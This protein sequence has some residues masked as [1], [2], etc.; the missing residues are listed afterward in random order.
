MANKDNPNGFKPTYTLSGGPPAIVYIPVANAQTLA[1][2]DAITLASG[3]VAI[4]TT[5]SGTIDG[6]MAAPSVTA[7]TNTLVP[8]YVANSDT[9]FEGQCSGNSAIALIGTSVDIEGTTGIMEVNENATTEAVLRIIEMHPSDSLGAN[10]R[11]RFVVEKSAFN[12]YSAA[13]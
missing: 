1:K 11:V 6:V 8:V 12:G 2:G 4:S 3:L 9:V 5:T 10:G 13:V 7:T